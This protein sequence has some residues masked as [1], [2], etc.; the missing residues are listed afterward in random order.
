MADDSLLNDGLRKLIGMES[1]PVENEVEK[2]AIIRFAEA[3]GDANALF[4][5]EAEARKTRYGGLI[6]PPTFY[7]SFKT[8]RQDILD[9]MAGHLTVTRRLDGGS[10]WE[11]HQPI[12]PGDRIATRVKLADI[13]EREGRLGR[14]LFTVLDTTYTNQFGEVTATQRTTTIAY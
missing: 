6:A 2:G 4:N 13:R 11:F 8:A 3:V 5:D 14:M 1:R 12:R 10:E 7:R 9:S